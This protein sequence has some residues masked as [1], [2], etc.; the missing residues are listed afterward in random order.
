VNS[1]YPKWAPYVLV[2]PFVTIFAIFMAYPMLYSAVMA[3]Q[4]TYGPKAS[5]FVFLDNFKNLMVDPFFW[6]AVRNTFVFAAGSVLIQLPLALGLAMLLNRPEVR[7]RVI[8]RLIFFSPALVGTVFIALMFG[9]MFNREGLVNFTLHGVFSAF[10][11]EFPW[12]ERFVMGSLIIASLWQYVGFNMIYFLA[13]LQNVSRDLAEA[14]MVDGAGPIARFLNVTIPAIRP[15]ASF[16]VLLSLIGSFQL[17]E[18]AWVLLNNSSG[19]NDQGMTVVMYL[20]QNG[21]VSFDLGYAS[22]IGWV[23]AILLMGFALVQHK[24]STIGED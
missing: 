18:L 20:Y 13:A 6:K 2:A 12:L 10:D 5:E 16:V 4:Q 15:I 24:V 14:A 19:P 22:A 21:F 7:G 23:L 9:L 11:P 3:M 1:G 8:F 17:F